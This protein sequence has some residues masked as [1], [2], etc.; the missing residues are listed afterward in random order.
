MAPADAAERAECVRQVAQRQPES[1]EERY[2][3]GAQGPASPRCPL[4]ADLHCLPSD[5]DGQWVLPPGLD[6]V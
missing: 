5:L 4:T 6:R 1:Q 3:A 2:L